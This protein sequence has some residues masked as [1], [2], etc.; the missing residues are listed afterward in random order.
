VAINAGAN[1]TFEKISKCLEND[2][3]GITQPFIC[4]PALLLA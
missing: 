3:T 4:V 2:A 1:K